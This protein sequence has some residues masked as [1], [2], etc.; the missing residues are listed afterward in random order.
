APVW[1]GIRNCTA[2]GPIAPQPSSRLERVTG[3]PTPAGP[4]D[5]D[6][7][8][9]TVWT[10]GRD[11]D[12]LPVLVWLHGGGFT[13]GSGSAEW[14][15]GR[16]LAERG[17]LVV[18]SVNYRL[19]ALGYLYL[20]E[21]AED[22]GAGN[23]GLLDM[24][25]ALHWVRDTIASFGGDPARV[26]VAGQSAGALSTV[27]MMANEAN[28]GLFHRAILQSGPYSPAA[29]PVAEATDVA[30]RFLAALGLRSG[31]ACRLRE[32]PVARLLAAQQS[33]A[34][35]LARPL[36]AVP[37]F[38]LVADGHVVPEDPVGL[39]G[40]GAGVG[41]PVLLGCNGDEAGAFLAGD[42]RLARLTR[43]DVL[44]ALRPRFGDQVED[45][46]ARLGPGS[47]ASVG[48]ALLG[49]CD[50]VR[51]QR[52]LAAARAAT[53]S[54]VYAYRFDWRPP[55]SV[56]GACHCLELP[57]VFGN[58]EAWRDAPMLPHGGRMPTALVDTVQ[59]AWI[60]FVRSGSP[61]G[62]GLARWP[63]HD[64]TAATVMRWT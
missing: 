24:I 5:E 43:E 25:S 13:S 6:C 32:V 47:P 46:Y 49:E 10:P 21:L 37:P 16:H 55:E 44:D 35:D 63:R 26:T 8:S 38:Q 14:Y 41:I 2:P 58:P 59:G 20:A 62:A 52:R 61:N 7:L 39:V 27:A 56:F 50:F 36:S 40:A 9:L 11:G 28:S 15:D 30:H 4:Q 54:P 12:R 29:A 45:E 31:D 51:P 22:M 53:G 33:V 1:T 64:G 42:E 18:V 48:A 57:F 3:P 60:S 34:R 23:Q 19:G 17:D